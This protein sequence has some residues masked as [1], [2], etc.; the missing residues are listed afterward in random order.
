MEGLDAIIEQLERQKAAIERALG[1]LQ[2]VGMVT[3]PVSHT[4]ASRAT[5]SH[6]TANARSIAQKARWAA[7]R[8]E[9]GP[10]KQ[11]GLTAAG[12]KRLADNMK[13]RWA[14]KRTGAQAK[15]RKKAA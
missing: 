11:S 1:A 10:K 7:V 9:A 5:A 6:D 2:A 14:A 8:G 15:R 12:R 4:P 13:K 3:A